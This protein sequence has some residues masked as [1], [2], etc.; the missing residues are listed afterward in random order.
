MV[1]LLTPE[2]Q[3]TLSVVAVVIFIALII[4]LNFRKKGTQKVLIWIMAIAFGTLM[5]VIVVLNGIE[6]FAPRVP[7]YGY[8]YGQ[9][10]YDPN[11]TSWHMGLILGL[12]ALISLSVGTILVLYDEAKYVMWHGLAAGGSLIVTIINIFTLVAL[13]EMEVLNYSG[14]LHILHIFLGAFGLMTGIASFLFGASG[15]R[16]LARMTGY[17]TLAGWWGAFL[18]GL[19]NTLPVPAI[20]FL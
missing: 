3:V 5:T 14:M 18:L 19:L 4:I 1:N 13:T 10:G 7:E 2:I 15:Q 9:V 12:P 8:K 6:I 16:N 17:F 20:Y 11:F